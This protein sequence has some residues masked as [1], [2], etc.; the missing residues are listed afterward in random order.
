MKLHCRIQAICP[1][2]ISDEEYGSELQRDDHEQEHME[3]LGEG[4]LHMKLA[5]QL[6]IERYRLPALRSHEVARWLRI[7]RR[8]A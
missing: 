6:E 1:W 7:A 3:M 8:A 5:W 2:S 4:L